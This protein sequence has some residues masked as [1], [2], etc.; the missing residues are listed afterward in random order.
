MV[1][2]PRELATLTSCPA[3][4]SRWVSVW[5]MAP[6]PRMP[7]LI[8]CSF[9][10]R[11]VHQQLEAPRRSGAGRAH[12]ERTRQLVAVVAVPYKAALSSRR[13]PPVPSFPLVGFDEMSH[14]RRPTNVEQL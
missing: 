1:S 13:R 8:S 2:G 3:A 12:V 10:M 9:S 14:L 11:V 6:T 4:L 5:P 7:I